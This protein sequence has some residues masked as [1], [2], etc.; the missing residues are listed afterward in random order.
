MSSPIISFPVSSAL[1]FTVTVTPFAT[2]AFTTFGVITVALAFI[3]NSLT[4]SAIFN[5]LPAASN[6]NVFP[7]TSSFHVPDFTSF[8]VIVPVTVALLF[9]VA[10]GAFTTKSPLI[11]KPAG[12]SKSAVAVYSIVTSPSISPV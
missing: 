9:T 12:K 2:V 6:T 8:I 4:S 1:A 11:V 5:V 7:E 3:V 10:F